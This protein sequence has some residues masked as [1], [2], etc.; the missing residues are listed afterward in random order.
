MNRSPETATAPGVALKRRELLRGLGRALPW[1]PAVGALGWMASV[2][3][4]ASAAPRRGAIAAGVGEAPSSDRVLVG[5]LGELAVGV[6]REVRLPDGGELRVTRHGA[7][8]EP[9]D[10]V[11]LSDRCPHLGCRVRWEA[12]LQRYRCPCHDGT[13]DRDGRPTGGPPARSGS[14][15]SRLPI[16]IERDVV[17]VLLAGAEKLGRSEDGR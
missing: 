14:S 16:V 1:V 7:G 12:A 8:A 4:R 10:F 9:S 15:L 2:L 5:P 13:F 11:A 17:W 6:E 3:W